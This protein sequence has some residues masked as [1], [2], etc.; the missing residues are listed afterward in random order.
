M[1]KLVPTQITDRNGKRTTV[2]KKPAAAPGTRS[3]LPAPSAAGATPPKPQGTPLV[4]PEPL[5]KFERAKYILS[6]NLPNIS[7]AASSTKETLERVDL[8][9]L[10]LAKYMVER[11]SL[12]PESVKLVLSKY[13]KPYSPM[14]VNRLLIAE[15]L[16]RTIG[17][18]V[19]GH[20]ERMN[21]L[22]AVTL[23]ADGLARNH[24]SG[25][26]MLDAFTTEE[27]LAGCSAAT[28]FILCPD[29][30]GSHVS[31]AYLSDG[32]DGDWQGSYIRNKHLD[33]L[34]R[35]RPEDVQAIITYVK[36]RGMHPA[37]KGPVK[38]LRA[39]LEDTSESS[40]VGTG[41]L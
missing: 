13:G 29:F 18:G 30:A 39:Y 24:P 23:A 20:S 7:F 9:G 6:N 10:A 3:A 12:D 16:E 38:A 4:L 34:I 14:Y 11:G 26:K 1:S 21:Y 32:E 36:E 25:A 17:K 2:H 33:L 27:E 22:Q 8:A 15:R 28:E 19:T 37:N 40:S 41:W 31:T 35:E 5:D